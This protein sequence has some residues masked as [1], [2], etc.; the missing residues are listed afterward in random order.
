MNEMLLLLMAIAFGLG[1]GFAL[2][3]MRDE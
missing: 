3:V 1:T 2:A